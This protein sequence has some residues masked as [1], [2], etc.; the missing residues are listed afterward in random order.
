MGGYRYY[1]VLNYMYVLKT[2]GFSLIELIITL[3]VMAIILT[4]AVPGFRSIVLDNKM[5]A[6]MNRLVNDLN[7]ARMEAI[8]RGDDVT[9]CKRN[10][11]GTDCDNASSWDRGWIV[12]S[13]PNRSGAVDA[14]EEIIRVSSE[15]ESG[16]SLTYSKN[17]I[18]YTSQGFSYGFAGTF[19][20][21]DTRGSSYARKRII[22]H[23]GR[24]RAA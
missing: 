4:I 21:T 3:S 11:S 9:I 20:M 12:F 13:D 8:K 2:S 7:L 17:R 5:T 24:I 1:R 23:T 15:L 10:T 6:D 18:T 14:G 22:S 16:I 19:V